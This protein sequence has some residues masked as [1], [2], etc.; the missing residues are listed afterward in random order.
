MSIPA[1]AF[2]LTYSAAHNAVRPKAFL[3]VSEWAEENRILSGEGSAEPGPWK[4]SRTPYL[5]EIM[6][7]LSEDS[8][9]KKIVFM[10]A[11]QIGGTECGSNWLGYIM[12]HAKG[13]VAVVMPSENS[14]NDWVSQKFEPMATDT[15]AVADALAKR[16]NRSADNN[17]KRKKFTGGIFYMK[18]AGSTA[19][20]KSTSLRYAIADEVDEWEWTTTQ[21]DPI[22][23][24]DVRMTTFHDSKMFIVSSPT[25][26]DA[27]HI[28]AQH[29]EGD[30]RKYHVPCPHCSELQVLRW[31]NLRY[32]K[33]PANPKRIT[34]VTYYCEHNGCV[35]EEYHKTEMLRERGYGGKARWI[36]MAPDNLYPSFQANSLYSPI[37]LGKSWTELAY[38]WINAQDDPKDLM[39]FIN[40]RLGETYRN[41]THDIKAN[42]L[43]ARAEPY[44]LRTV[45]IGALIL[46]AGVD[47][48]DD[49]LEM[50]I[51]GHGRDDK[52]WPIDYHVIY[53]NPADQKIWDALAEY[54]KAKFTNHYGRE[55]RIEATAIDTGG[56]HT[57]AV[58]SFC[59][60]AAILG[61][62]R[63]IAIKGAS[64]TG[65]AILGKPSLQ[66]VN[67]RGQT[68]KK[69]VALYTV[70]T[71]T[72]KHLIYNRLNGDNDKD[73]SQ[74][75]MHFSTELPEN[76][77]DQLV[78][79]TFNPR[80]NRWELKKGKRN[81]VL[82][83]KVYAIAVSHHPELYLHKWKKS[84]WDKREAMVQP[85]GMPATE[86]EVNDASLQK[87]TGV[88]VSHGAKLGLGSFKRGSR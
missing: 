58:Y 65:R 67:W 72:A 60:G 81:E 26:K 83:T 63:C 2:L 39:V 22:E 33:D 1:D 55:L 23:L 43:Q 82:D 73:P 84:D 44:Q 75:K 34:S 78:S 64:T 80:K 79:E 27:S 47:V 46:T 36:A 18:T 15:P 35:I 49:R 20:L 5:R 42:V 54:L 76:Y 77:Y 6:D 12:D 41:A 88:S 7:C 71:D 51:L 57:H 31:S 87:T 25:I 66:D 50:Q 30:Q 61:I 17:S 53:G 48:Q 4:N 32:Q 11:S 85:V 10:K 14:L 70:G 37:G 16:S 52:I 86:P 29:D 38:Q 69:G 19:D 45:P 56:H 3:T 59:R 9:D 13:P 68:M 8:P 28:E 21:G 40:T 62:P 24:L 74:R